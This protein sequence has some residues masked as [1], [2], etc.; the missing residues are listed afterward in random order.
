MSEI[1][2]LKYERSSCCATSGETVRK[3]VWIQPHR[4]LTLSFLFS[5]LSCVYMTTRATLMCVCVWCECAAIYSVG[6]GNCQSQQSNVR[7]SFEEEFP[8]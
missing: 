4:R 1:S 7:E 2:E 3:Q 5:S 6:N 8:T